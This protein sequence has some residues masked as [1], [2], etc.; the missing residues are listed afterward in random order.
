MTKSEMAK[1]AFSIQGDGAKTQ[2]KETGQRTDKIAFST[3]IKHLLKGKIKCKGSS[4]ELV[5]SYH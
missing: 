1:I 4:I 3:G 2:Y 5:L